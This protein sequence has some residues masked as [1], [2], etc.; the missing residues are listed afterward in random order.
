ME[1]QEFNNQNLDR[2]KQVCEE[3]GIKLTHQ[4]LEIY[5]EL[6][7]VKDHP[8]AEQV[9]GRLQERMPTI[10]ID[11]VYRTLATF[12]ELGI[13]NKLHIASENTLFDINV[14]PHHHFICAKCKRVEDIYWPDFDKSKLP[15][16]VSAIGSIKKRHLE[17]YGICSQCLKETSA[18]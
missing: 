5:K 1:K 7:S 2:I 16:S 14:N 18:G 17:L 10:A 3:A 12:E 4:R 8:S 9:H 11:T 6:V 15:E 13:I